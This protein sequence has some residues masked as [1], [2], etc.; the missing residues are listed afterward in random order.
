M[1]ARL[2]PWRRR[3][4]FLFNGSG[5]ITRTVARSDSVTLTRQVI[6]DYV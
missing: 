5:A 2:K 3:A 4:P 6:K 1:P